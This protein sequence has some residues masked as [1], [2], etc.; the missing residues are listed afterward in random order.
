MR[1]LNKRFA[2][3]TVLILAL[4]N[5]S[6]ASN[7]IPSKSIRV[8]ESFINKVPTVDSIPKLDEGIESFTTKSSSP[9][10]TESDVGLYKSGSRYFA[11]GY[12][13]M[14]KGTSD[15]YHYTRA[16]MQAHEWMSIVSDNIYG[17][18][19]VWAE[20]RPYEQYGTARV[21]YGW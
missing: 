7:D 4:S 14:K 2:L 11:K 8:T 16:E 21:Y 15:F 3:T 9:R 20:T 13:T 1:R 12:V 17:H 10:V 5:I 18:G 6:I 19:K